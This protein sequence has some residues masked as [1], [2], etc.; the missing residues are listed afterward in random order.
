MLLIP[1]FS[2]KK[3]NLS[4]GKGLVKMSASASWSI[5]I[6]T[7][8]SA[9]STA[10]G[11]AATGI[12][13]TTIDGGLKYSSNIDTKEQ[14]GQPV[15]T[16]EEDNGI[17]VA[18]DPQALLGFECWSPNIRNNLDN[19]NSSREED[20]TLKTMDP[21]DLLGSL[22]FRC[23]CSRAIGLLE[24][25]SVVVVILVK[26]HSF[27]TIVKVRLVGYDPLALA[28]SFTLVEDN[29]VARLDAIRIYFAFAAHMNMIVYQMDAKTT[30]LNGIL[31]EEVYIN[32]PDGF[33]DKDNPNHVYKLK[34]ALYG[35]KQAPHAVHDFQ[36]GIESYQ[37][38]INLSTP[39][40]TI[41]DIKNLKP[42]IIINEPF[43]RIVY[44]NSKNEK[45]VIYTEEIP[46]LYDATLKK[47]L[48]KVLEINQEVYYGYKDLL[49]IDVEKES[50]SHDTQERAKYKR[51][52]DR[53]MNNRM[54]QSKEGNVDSSKTLDAGLVGTKSNET[55]SERHVSSSI[56][57]KDTHVEDADINFVND[58][59]PMAKVKQTAKH[60]IFANEQQHYEQSEST[61]DTHLLEKVDRNTTPVSTYMSHRG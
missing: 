48:M 50:M 46:K 30:F 60:N 12:R 9:K 18:L 24:V 52:Y 23:V 54:M 37:Y 61:Y 57:K 17:S 40:L 32:Q 38:K 39:T 59:Q 14:S 1:S 10:L 55:E 29:A 16:R 56:F 26:G 8:E 20:G 7:R 35:L 2:I 19:L 45:R 47:V 28:D 31:R 11:A 33:V 41:P 53:K 58:K 44:E 43:I 3:L 15:M 51:E 4:L 25:T 5:D 49:L 36:L 42:Y 34:K 21:Q 22:L 6:D 13:E 27:P